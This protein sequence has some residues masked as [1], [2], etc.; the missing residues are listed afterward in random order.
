MQAQPWTHPLM[1]GSPLHPQAAGR[2]AAR[3][4]RATATIEITRTRIKASSPPEGRHPTPGG[5]VGASA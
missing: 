5:P 4:E 3:S 1:Q 2:G